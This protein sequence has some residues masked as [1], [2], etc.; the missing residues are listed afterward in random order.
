MVIAPT[1][2][3]PYA[4]PPS[5][6]DTANFDARADAKVAD[7]AAKVVEYND[8][9]V[10]VYNNALAA[11]AAA[12][13]SL[14]AQGLAEAAQL[15]AEDAANQA[16]GSAGAAQWLSGHAYA[17]GDRVWS[18]VNQQLYRRLGSGAGATDPAAD[19]VNWARVWVEAELV[20]AESF[21]L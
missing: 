5:S 20:T 19:S 3:T 14:I 6:M 2:I 7:D 16:A 4:T 9:A 18:P 21:F 17:N 8:L 15:A 10:N 1:P 12:L 13:G 11:E